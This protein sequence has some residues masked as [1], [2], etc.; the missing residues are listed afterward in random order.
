MDNIFI[1]HAR[2]YTYIYI[3]YIYIYIYI[4][5]YMYIYIF[6]YLYINI[7]FRHIYSEVWRFNAIPATRAIFMMEEHTIF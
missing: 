5:I 1:Y 7:I 3:I 2:V 6:I 4:H